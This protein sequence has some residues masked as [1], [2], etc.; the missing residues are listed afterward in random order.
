[1]FIKITCPLKKGNRLC[2]P[3]PPPPRHSVQTIP[4]KQ[5]PQDIPPKTFLPGLSPYSPPPPGYF[6]HGLV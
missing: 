5:F 3:P 2:F 4:S 6:L 1:M